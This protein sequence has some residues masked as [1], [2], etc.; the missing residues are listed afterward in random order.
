M[1]TTNSKKSEIRTKFLTNT[2]NGEKKTFR[3]H[4]VTHIHTYLLIHNQKKCN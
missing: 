3:E 2:M 1:Q 4:E